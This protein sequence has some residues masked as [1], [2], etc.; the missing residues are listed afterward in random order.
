[1]RKTSFVIALA[2]VLSLL[3]PGTAWADS[4][5]STEQTGTG[6]SSYLDWLGDGW[7]WVSG[8]LQSGYALL[9]DTVAEFTGRT[10][11]EW[12]KTAESYLMS[13]NWPEEV[14]N[15]WNVLREG[16]ENAGSV[17]AEEATEAYHTVRDWLIS[18]GVLT[19]EDIAAA[20]D[21]I[22]GAAGVTEATLSGWYRIV[23]NYITENRDAMS[24]TVREAW[25]TIRQAQSQG[26][27]MAGDTLKAAYQTV[28][29]WINS[30]NTDDA[31]QAAEA[32]EHIMSL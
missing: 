10:I 19:Q 3:F 8:K 9:D 6:E 25:D 31:E 16:A 22:A 27:E 1:M 18:S 13:S 29:N 23:E 7:S 15:A 30:A 20:L 17:A 5:V 14:R 11:G 28:Y 21:W 24:E 12:Q 2:L 4:A 32:M 26:L